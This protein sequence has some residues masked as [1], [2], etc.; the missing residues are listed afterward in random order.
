MKTETGATP[1]ANITTVDGV[2]LQ[3][4]W[5]YASQPRG[6]AVVLAHGFTGSKDDPA[7]GAVAESL[8]ALGH[9]VLAYDARGH[10]GSEGLCTLGDLERHDVAAAVA[11]A[12]ERSDRVVTVGASMGAIAVLRHAAT[13]ADLAGVVSVSGPALWRLPRN[14]RSLFAA[15]LTRTTVGRRVAARRLHV[16]LSRRWNDP[17]P[18]QAL[19]ARIAVPM[20]V[21]HGRNDR[22]VPPTEAALLASAAPNAHL[23]LVPGMGH[24]FDRAAVPAVV[25]AVEWIAGGS[26]PGRAS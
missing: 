16:H 4:R 18:P 15:V 11:A 2:R 23:L 10:H 1:T 5:W 9:D 21:I 8:R 12:R 24:A 20:A 25:R 14:V 3:A 7:L 17:E 13:D 22:F 6:T 26:E 19:A